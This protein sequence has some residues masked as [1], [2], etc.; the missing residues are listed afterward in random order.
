VSS[1][2]QR[3]ATFHLVPQTMLPMDI[4]S[5]NLPE[6][7]FLLRPSCSPITAHRAR[8]YISPPMLTYNLSDAELSSDALPSS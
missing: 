4:L 2:H 1:I 8:Q 5:V 7:T 3:H 6:Y